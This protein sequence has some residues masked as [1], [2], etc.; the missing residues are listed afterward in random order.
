[1][2]LAYVDKLARE[3][4]GEKH[5]L[6]CQD[7]FERSINARY[8][9]QNENWKNEWGGFQETV[10]ALSSMITKSNRPKKIWVDKGT[11]FAGSFRIFVLLR[12]TSLLYYE[13]D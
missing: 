7:L 2:D 5:L 9:K 12:D 4:N 1:M 13:W 3:N 8:W 11:E 6:V 10:K